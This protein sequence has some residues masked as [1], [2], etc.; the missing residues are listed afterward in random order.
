MEVD[1]DDN[2]IAPPVKVESPTEISTVPLE[3][4]M[5]LPVFKI[6]LPDFSNDDVPVKSTISPLS[7]SLVPV[8]TLMP[9]DAIDE[10]TSL[11]CREIAT[12]ED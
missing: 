7:V 5:E 2:E 11:L 4:A 9:P 1:P 12:F 6:T 3:P 10:A 8:A